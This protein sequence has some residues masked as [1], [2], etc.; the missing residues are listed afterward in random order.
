MA[1]VTFD[2]SEVDEY[3]ADLRR[4]PGELARHLVPVVKRAAQNIK[5]AQ[6]ADFR[7]SGNRAIAGIAGKVAYDEPSHTGGTI[8][9]EV[10][11]DK[12]SHGNLG[13]IAVY[14]TW[15]GGGT[16]LHPAFYADQEMPGFADYLA[17]VAA[18]LIP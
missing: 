6:Q 13:N 11:V 5:V 9:T 7:G 4:V 16:H 18:G 15:K 10:G 3:V 2:T 8:E 1:K 12:G 17:Q 14:G